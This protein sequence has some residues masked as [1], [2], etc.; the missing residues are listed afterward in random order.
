LLHHQRVLVIEC[1]VG[2]IVDGN[3]LMKENVN[4]FYQMMKNVFYHP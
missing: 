2:I 3:D 1:Q 4:F